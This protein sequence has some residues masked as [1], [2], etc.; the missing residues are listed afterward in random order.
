MNKIL[1]SSSYMAWETPKEFYDK[2]DEEFGFTLDVCANAD[3]HKCELYLSERDD[4]LSC[5]WGGNICWMNPPY[6]RQISKWIKK[7]Y[8]S[9]LKGAIVVCLIPART[10]TAYWWDYCMKG[11]IRFI[12]G[13]IKFKGRNAKGEIV[14]N[15][16]TFP[17]A[18]VIFRK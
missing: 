5:D 16:A 18:I 9:S 4:G 6:G 13:R 7:A 17:S 3:N 11:E 8:E 12:R 14:Q 10:D 2:L 15:S 1:L